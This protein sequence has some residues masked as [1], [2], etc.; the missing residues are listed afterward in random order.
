MVDGFLKRGLRLCGVAVG[1]L[2]SFASPAGAV[3]VTEAPSN[4]NIALAFG[5]LA[6]DTT[7]TGDFETAGDV[8]WLV[9]Y[10]RDA[11]PNLHVEVT[12]LGA[13]CSADIRAGVYD[14]SGTPIQVA[15]LVASG[16][17]RPFDVPGR[18]GRFYVRLSRDGDCTGDPYAVTV[19]PTTAI[20]TTPPADDDTPVRAP[21]LVLEPN[22]SV[23]TASGPLAPG[24]AYGGDLASSDDREWLVFYTTGVATPRVQVTRLGLPCGGLATLAYVT[25]DT[26]DV[27]AV[28]RQTFTDTIEELSFTSTGPA[29]YYVALIGGC[30]GNSYQVRVDPAGAIDVNSPLIAFAPTSNP[31]ATAEPNETPRQASRVAGGTGYGA[32]ID[33][34]Y[35]VDFFVFRLAEQR[36]VDVSVTKVGDGCGNRLETSVRKAAAPSV[37]LAEHYVTHN[38]TVRL[39]IVADGAADYVLRVAGTCAGDPYQLRIDPGDAVIAADGD[40]DGTPDS[41]DRCPTLASGA[42]SGCPAKVAPAG[43]RLVLVPARDTRSPFRFRVAGSVRLPR[44]R[45]AAEACRGK[46]AIR[47]RSGRRSVAFATTPLRPDC[48][49]GRTFRFADRRLFPRA[50]RLRVSATFRGNVLLR[51]LTRTAGA[52]VR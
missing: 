24:T 7:Y 18:S 38:A 52:R 28:G 19:G 49:Y 21:Q 35:D 10:V 39:R 4:D 33:S 3:A 12:K 27:V 23:A 1:L 46:V 6:A 26:G 50:R 45:P 9:L 14:R 32:S 20:T 2:L 51:A 41:R 15:V 29:R 47:F 42:A 43:M 22:D 17:T 8:D 25:A 30:P 36:Q 34:L 48:R 5:P 40:A 44:G 13:G 11:A 16:T 31:L 37:V